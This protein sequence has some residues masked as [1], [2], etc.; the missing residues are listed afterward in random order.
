MN[1]REYKAK[2]LRCFVC[3]LLLEI[4]YVSSRNLARRVFFYKF[5]I[6]TEYLR[7]YFEI[8]LFKLMYEFQTSIC[9]F[10]SP[11]RERVGI[12]IYSNHVYLY[13]T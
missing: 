3:R 12:D 13:I 9:S 5:R 1:E 10:V 7:M 8:L 6:T 11:S 2:R 4:R